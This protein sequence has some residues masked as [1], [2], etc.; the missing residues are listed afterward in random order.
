MFMGQHHVTRLVSCVLDM[1]DVRPACRTFDDLD[2][3]G[4]KG[5]LT[6]PEA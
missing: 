6:D 3:E 5:V 4:E 1:P 2:D